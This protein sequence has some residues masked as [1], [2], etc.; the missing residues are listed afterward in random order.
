MEYK[1]RNEILV[2][3]TH[4]FTYYYVLNAY[5]NSH[6]KKKNMLKDKNRKN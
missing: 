5:Y 6:D 4:I 2:I 1:L 3:N